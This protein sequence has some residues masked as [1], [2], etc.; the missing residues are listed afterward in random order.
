MQS[1]Q[2]NHRIIMNHRE[3]MMSTAELRDYLR[4]HRE[5]IKETEDLYDLYRSPY[6]ARSYA[7]DDIVMDA[8][9]NSI[10]RRDRHIIT[11]FDVEYPQI[12]DYTNGMPYYLSLLTNRNKDI[13]GHAQQ[14]LNKIFINNFI[15]E[16]APDNTDPEQRAERAEILDRIKECNKGLY[17][18]LR[19]FNHFNIL[20]VKCHSIA[21]IVEYDAY[22]GEYLSICKA[23][24]SKEK[25]EQMTWW[26]TTEYENALLPDFLQIIEEDEKM[27]KFL[28]Y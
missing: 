22:S 11:A 27:E 2:R 18:K 19:F 20:N 25:Y 1:H 5:L 13:V 16:E 17:R 8:L 28:K 4:N 24:Y 9:Q 6:Y 21:E 26:T 3:S 23:L 10:T 14:K 7:I 12:L 15:E